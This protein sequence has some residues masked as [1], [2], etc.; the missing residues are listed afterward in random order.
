MTLGNVKLIL[1]REIRDQLRDRR[2]LFMIAVLPILLY[3]LLGISMLQVSQFMQEQ[4]TRVLVVGANHL[5]ARPPLFENGQFATRLFGDPSGARLLEL[6][7]VSAE[8]PTPGAAPADLRMEADAE[9]A[10]GHFEAALYF[11]PDFA[12][13]LEA[14]RAAVRRQAQGRAGGRAGD[15][16]AVRLAVPSPEI[17]HSTANEKSELA[18]ARLSGVLQRWS[19]QIGEDNLVQSGVSRIAARPFLVG[20]ADVAD[21][22]HRGASFWARILPVL[23]LLWTLTGAFYPAIDLCAGEKERGTLETLLCSPAERSEIVVGKLLTIML[24]SILT[25]VLNLLSMGITGWML[26]SQMPG[27]GLPPPVAIVALAIAVVPMAA[28]FST[29]CLALA[30]FARSTKEGQYYLMPLLCITLPLVMLPMSPGVDLNLGNS[31][32]PVTGVVLLL[33]SVLEGNY[34]QAIQ[35]TPVVSM[36]TLIACLLSIRWAVEQFNSESVLFRES[37]RL[38][39]GLWLQRLWSH[40]QPTP[41]VAA[42]TCCG[43]LILVAHFFLSV[44]AAPMEGLGGFVRAVLTTQL[45]VIAAPALL[46]TLLLTRSLR[47]TLLLKRPPWLAVPA[48]A[49]LAVALH[50][51]SNVLQ[52]LVQHLYHVNENLRPALEKV[53]A[54]FHQADFW[55]LVLV[56]AIVPALCEELA[57]RGFILSGFRHLGHKWRAIVFTSLLFG[58]THGVVQ[59]S[60]LACLLGMVLGFL[61]VQTGS[62]LPGM[63]F[64]VVHNT[65]AVSNARIMPEMVPHAP[66][67]RTFVTPLDGGGCGF[68]WPVAV[69]G[70]LAAVLLLMWFGRLRGP[71]SPEEELTE[72]IERGESQQLSL[73]PKEAACGLAGDR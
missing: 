38:N 11:P 10:A 27:L 46:M 3:P 9:V 59:Q 20:S 68:T 73:V 24:F 47:Q 28:L 70:L 52:S 55:T 42:A 13:R 45:A 62:I 63:V 71:K 8:P 33:R 56:I 23:L 5:A 26:M 58:M 2:T 40:R 72:A 15:E 19:E 1:G 36:V 57:F 44:S 54:M 41:T 61:A 14:F 17:V 34:W 49:L 30:A 16:P 53:Q 25:V 50:P 22:K 6:H 18:F 65:L 31:L 7:F 66:A 32:I 39:L 43:T 48:A 21:P 51:V 64:H 69:V 35:F 29:L 67:L 37:E 12:R 4:A 60:L